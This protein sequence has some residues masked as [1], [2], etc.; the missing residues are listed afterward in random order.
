MLK[1]LRKKGVAK[2]VI[3][4]V[5]IVIIISFGFL[6]T[7]Y[8]LT[9]SSQA[10]YAG[11]IFG[12]KIEIDEFQ[13]MYE[14]VRIQAIMKYGDKF[15]DVQQYLDLENE[16]WDRLILLDDV[17]KKRIRVSNEEVVKAIEEIPFFQR[18]GQFDTLLYN[19]IIRFV[20][21]IKPR[22]FEESMR[23][24]LKFS[25]LFENVTDK[26]EV[27]EDEIFDEYKRLNEK[28]QISYV[29]FDPAKF[30]NEA[31]FDEKK[32]KQYFE[33]SKISFILPASI[34]ISYLEIPFPEE[35]ENVEDNLKESDG[36][37]N[38]RNSA[39]QKA[40]A[41]YEDLLINP[42]IDE[43][44]QKQQLSV[45]ET[46]FFS[47]EN[48][49]TSLGW[50]FEM[51]ND[52]FNHQEGQIA[53]PYETKNNFVIL[54]IKNKKDS[55]MPT[56]DDVKEQVKEAFIKQEAKVIAKNKANEYLQLIKQQYIEA[57]SKDFSEIIKAFDLEINQTPIFNRGQYLPK[58]GISLDFEKAAFSLNDKKR[59]SSVVSA[60]PGAYILHLDKYIP[61]EK[62][63]YHDKREDIINKLLNEKRNDSFG[64]YLN[65]L[66][67][68]ASL[69]SN[70]ENLRVRNQSM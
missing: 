49:N 36:S 10:S 37:G 32:S 20:F 43:I 53:G 50:S 8:L 67:A 70:L 35:N 23:D 62:D 56:Y 2:K 51:L 54:K 40:Q 44:A 30:T 65:Q 9:D 63:A 66:R 58:I 13:K 52:L 68:K 5:A 12:K 27:S 11:K 57:E 38:E 48:P 41:I 1:L 24:T 14:Q 31:L 47:I 46:G 29:L 26:I 55:M 45:K 6:G 59:L 7:A 4:F 21:R 22:E 42:K 39:Q 34:N 33:S 18:D 69:E 28:V 16:T 25:R 15:R 61:A 64:D 3:W 17:N 19:D 60:E